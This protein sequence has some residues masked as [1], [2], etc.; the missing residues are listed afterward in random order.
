MHNLHYMCLYDHNLSSHPKQVTIELD[1]S[2]LQLHNCASRFFS[3]PFEFCYNLIYIPVFNL[4]V[5]HSSISPA[6]FVHH[7]HY[8]FSIIIIIQF[9]LQESIEMYKNH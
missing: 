7:R 6:L 9:S 1:R 5:Q 2:S 4:N 3:L 8:N